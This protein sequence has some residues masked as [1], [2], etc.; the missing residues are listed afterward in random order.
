MLNNN[1]PIKDLL[2]TL[3]W[4]SE[5]RLC[6]PK[7]KSFHKHQ[8]VQ[9][10]VRAQNSCF[11]LL[12]F[13][14]RQLHA[15]HTFHV[16]NFSL[17]WHLITSPLEVLNAME[18]VLKQVWLN[19][20]PKLLIWILDEVRD[21]FLLIAHNLSTHW[22]NTTVKKNSLRMIIRNTANHSYWEAILICNIIGPKGSFH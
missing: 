22:Y 20:N 3:P 13:D 9:S 2:R 21:S 18:T 1:F 14:E 16:N 17:K 19:P 8:S 12:S 10:I 15:P 7:Q 6:F 4:E 5:E 11:H